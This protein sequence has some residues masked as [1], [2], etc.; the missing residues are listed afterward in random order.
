MCLPTPPSWFSKKS[1]SS[2]KGVLEHKFPSPVY[3]LFANQFCLSS[4]SITNRSL[5]LSNVLHLGG[6]VD[7]LNEQF[8]VNLTNYFQATYK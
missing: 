2:G 8:I 1:V 7:N 3:I 6:I 5:I 4:V